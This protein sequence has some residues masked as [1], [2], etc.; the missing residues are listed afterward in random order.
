MTHHNFVEHGDVDKTNT[1]RTT[2]FKNEKINS[3]FAEVKI[4]I[5]LSHN[6]V[7]LSRTRPLR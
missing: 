3:C 5:H 1:P 7:S 2:S 4:K 6:I